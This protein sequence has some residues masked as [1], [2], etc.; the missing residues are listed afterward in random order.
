MTGEIT[1]LIRAS[2]AFVEYY[3]KHCAYEEEK[4]KRF[5]EAANLARK[6][7]R[8]EAWRIAQGYDDVCKVFDY[9]KV[10][11]GMVKAVKPFRGSK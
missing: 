4:T 2:I 3:E 1:E 11:A 10:N 6:G 5:K 7:K 8:L 9:S